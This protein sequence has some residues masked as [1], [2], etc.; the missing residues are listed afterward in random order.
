MVIPYA[1]FIDTENRLMV[2]RDLGVAGRY[3][4][5]L[6]KEY[7]LPLIRGIHSRDQMFSKVTI[8]KYTILYA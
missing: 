5:V 2:A 7:K 8:I 4:E 3:W 1:K 6:V